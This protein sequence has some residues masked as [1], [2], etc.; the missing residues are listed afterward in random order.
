MD[1]AILGFESCLGLAFVG[2]A[3]MLT[4]SR[5]MLAKRN[6]PELYRVM[7]VSHDG[8]PVRDGAGRLLEVDGRFEDADGCAA[9][10]VPGYLCDGGHALPATPAIGAAAAWLRRQHAL[11]AIV[12][13][14]CN[15]VFLL[16][17]AGLLDGRRCTTTWW[18]H[19]ELKSRYPRADAA[20]GASLIEDGRVV[21]AGGPLSWIDLSLHVIR[22]LLGP[23]AAKKAGDF[24][25]VDAA[26]STQAIYI[27]PGH[28]SASNPFL[29]EAEHIVRQ[30]GDTQLTTIDLAR[31]LGVSERTLHRRL[32]EASGETPKHFLDRVRFETARM[33]LETTQKSVKQLAA[34]SGY[35]D[36]TSFRRA[37]RRYSGMTPGAYRSWSAAR[38]GAR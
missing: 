16:G 8:R 27:P 30:A 7:S 3:D 38:R 31:T 23:E 15:G 17:E 25:V 4:L 22:A 28:L 20:W 24:T 12:A 18:R 32:K 14:S 26:P 1:I 10:I 34:A 21:T 19:N 35:M 29:L 5:R 6:A 13:G 11:G 9:I 36:E 33:L 37:F 2:S